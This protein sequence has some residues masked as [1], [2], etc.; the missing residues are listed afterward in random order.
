MIINRDK[1]L[2]VFKK[3]RQVREEYQ[4]STLAG[5]HPRLS[6]EDIYRVVSQA[7]NMQI[8]KTQVVFEAQFLRGMIERYA[9]RALIR[10]RQ[11]QEDDWKRFAAVKELCHVFIDEQEDWSTEGVHTIDDLLVE[12]A[13]RNGHESHRVTQSEILAEIAAIEIMYPYDHRCHDLEQL[14]ERNTTQIRIATYFAIPKAIVS[15]AL[16]ENHHSFA[17]PLWESLNAE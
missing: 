14:A 9:D 4:A 8:I 7:Y 17:T 12:Y 13:I 10:V 5:D 16:S 15:R 11:D 6:I 3:V 2:A 1:A